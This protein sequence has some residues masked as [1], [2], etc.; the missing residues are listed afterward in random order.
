MTQ[1]DGGGPATDMTMRDYFAAAAM[2]AAMQAAFANP[3]VA[4]SI[5][6]AMGA[7]CS[8]SGGSI[9][10]Y[11]WAIADAMLAARERSTSDA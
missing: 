11:S 4:E 5:T 7:K 6:K 3:E 1:P 8:I 9:A 10:D 2:Q